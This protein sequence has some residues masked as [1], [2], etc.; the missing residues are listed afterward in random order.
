ILDKKGIDLY[1]EPITQFIGDNGD[2]DAIKLAN[3]KTVKV[4][5][6]FTKMDWDT[7]FSFLENLSI[8]RDENDKIE[9]RSEERRVG[10]EYRYRNVTGVQTCALPIFI[11]DKKGID[12]YTEPIT[13]FIGDNGDLDAIKLANEKTVKV[14][15]A[16]TKMDW[17]THFS[18][19][20]NLSIKRDEN[21]KIEI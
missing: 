14:E 6:A 1:T 18:F 20:E 16:F 2:L 9:I 3:E 11:I 8:K 15:G 17:D 21:D 7:H 13:Q 19:L 5:G 4:E 10:K 12:L